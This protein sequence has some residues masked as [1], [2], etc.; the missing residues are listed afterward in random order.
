[1]SAVNHPHTRLFTEINRHAQ[2]SGTEVGG[3]IPFETCGGLVCRRACMRDALQAQLHGY[4]K[5]NFGL[6]LTFI[7]S[8]QDKNK[9][10]AA[11]LYSLLCCL[12]RGGLHGPWVVLEQ[13]AR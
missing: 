7:L 11:C 3:R 9:I 13:G 5:M 8:A 10:K 6:F 4:L 1:M 12:P 2:Q